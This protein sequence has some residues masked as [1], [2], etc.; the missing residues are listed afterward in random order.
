MARN[1]S[2]NGT[3]ARQ[4]AGGHPGADPHTHPGAEEDAPG[5]RAFLRRLP[6]RQII[7][8]GVAIVG[9]YFVWP[10]LVSFYSQVPRLQGISWF[11]FVFM[12]LLEAASFVCAWGLM[13]LTLHERS[14]FL[15]A[16]AQLTSNSVSRL[17][18]GGAASGGTASY[19]MFA[20][21]GA[22][23][24]R[25]VSGLT[26]TSL[27]STAV[28][29]SLPVLS[30]PAIAFGGAP[31]AT[32]LLRSLTYGVVV[33]A[34]LLAV[35]AVALLTDRPLQTVGT[36]AQRAHNRLRRR[37]PPMAGLARRLIEER[38]L[39]KGML[40]RRWWEALPFAAGNWL[41]DYVALLAALAAVGVRPRA[42]V[43]L[44]AYV[45]AALL[46]MVPITP[47]GL[48][49]VEAGLAAT[50]TL[51]GI[52]AAEATLATL[53]YRLVS[54]WMPIPAGGVAYVLYRRRY[55]TKNGPKNGTKN[56][57]TNGTTNGGRSG[58]RG[59][60]ADGDGPAPAP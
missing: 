30:L 2:D 58:A 44:L 9:L 5:P 7:V 8:F 24:E 39:I 23:A 50:L 28:L 60:T 57:T 26:A 14:W 40:G 36:L 6:L 53:A 46:G 15:I 35:G 52:G 31:V 11:W 38:D 21:T 34:L 47:G 45:V 41:L 13:R 1:M 12:G 29:I 37:R 42:S 51:A 56:G 18:P 20:A 3:Q 43:V 25:I 33:F 55:G 27:I 19:Q 49:F 54:F 22:P 48:G 32:T 4:G 59:A 17:I 10:Q 16:T